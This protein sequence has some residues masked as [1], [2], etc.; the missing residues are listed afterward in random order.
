MRKIFEFKYFNGLIDWISGR[1]LEEAIRNLSCCTRSD[2]WAYMADA[3]IKELER[4]EWGNHYTDGDE[5]TF[6]EK[7]NALDDCDYFYHS[8]DY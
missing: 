3:K 4:G 6:Q 1:S 2:R 5:T 7:M 8:N